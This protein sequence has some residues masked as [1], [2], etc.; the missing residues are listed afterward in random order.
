MCSIIL[1]RLT[2]E[3]TADVYIQL[4]YVALCILPLCWTFS[5]LPPLDALLP[6][7]M[8]QTLTHL[9]GGSPMATDFRWKCCT[10]IPK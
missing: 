4:L 1:C 3:N 9:M 6:W 10:H 2:V 7:V 5:V 8:E